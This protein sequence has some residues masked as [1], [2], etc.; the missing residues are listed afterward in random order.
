MHWEIGPENQR[1]Q[2]HH[3]GQVWRGYLQTSEPWL[4]T[5]AVPAQLGLLFLPNLRDFAAA[6]NS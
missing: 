4:G 1:R 6:S 3:V 2:L 5:Q